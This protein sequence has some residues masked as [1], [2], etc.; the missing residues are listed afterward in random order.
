MHFE[1]SITIS[2]VCHG[3]F[4]A[5]FADDRLGFGEKGLLRGSGSI[6]TKPSKSDK[7]PGRAK[8][9]QDVT[10]ALTANLPSSFAE[11]IY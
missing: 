5:K 9:R 10:K 11:N 1:A 6:L 2:L 8:Q 4:V 3:L 7:N